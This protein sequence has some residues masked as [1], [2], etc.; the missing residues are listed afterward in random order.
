MVDSK[1][2]V[3]LLHE[4]CDQQEAKHPQYEIYQRNEIPIEFECFVNAFGKFAKG[5]GRSKSDA[6]H[7][8][9]I[10]LLRELNS[11]YSCK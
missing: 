2:P 6:K 1:T 9:C 4:F 11:I 5:T 8:A 3:S 7:A 10:E